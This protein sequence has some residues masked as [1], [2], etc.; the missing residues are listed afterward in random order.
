MI[1]RGEPSRASSYMDERFPRN[2][3]NRRK[4]DGL[5]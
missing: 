2:N 5:V 1:P 3:L 4:T